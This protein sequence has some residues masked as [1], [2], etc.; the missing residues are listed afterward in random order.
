MAAM[1]GPMQWSLRAA[2]SRQLDA[3][4]C[5]WCVLLRWIAIEWT[6]HSFY[7]W[8]TEEFWLSWL[9]LCCLQAMFTMNYYVSCNENVLFWPL[10]IW[11]VF[12]LI[13]INWKRSRKWGTSFLIMY[14]KNVWRSVRVVL[15]VRTYVKR[16]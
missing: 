3:V 15:S 7:G 6:K 9:H 16:R 2:L 14:Q 11:L 8:L 10:M 1:S 5:L 12:V 13:Y 4:Q